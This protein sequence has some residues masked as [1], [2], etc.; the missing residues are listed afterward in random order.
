MKCHHSLITQ[1]KIWKRHLKGDLTKFGLFIVI[2][3]VYS[4]FPP[5]ILNN[6]DLM[7]LLTLC[8]KRIEHMQV[9]NGGTV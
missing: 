9:D 4:K 5:N 6:E 2:L 1:W 7:N 8:A 3:D